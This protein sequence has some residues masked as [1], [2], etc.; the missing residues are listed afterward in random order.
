MRHGGTQAQLIGPDGSVYS[1]NDGT[2][3]AVGQ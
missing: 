3:F 2:L 1:I